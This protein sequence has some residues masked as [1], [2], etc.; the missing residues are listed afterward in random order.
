MPA[1]IMRMISAAILTFGVFL[2]MSYL[3]APGEAPDEPTKN[4][5]RIE[6]LRKNR[7][8]QPTNTDFELPPPPQMAKAPPPIMAR[9][10]SQTLAPSGFQF[11]KSSMPKP[12]VIGDG[13]TANRRAVPVISFPP[14]YPMR[15][16]QNEIEGWVM[17]EFTIAVDG[18][19]TDIVV[20]DA[21]PKNA[22]GFEREAIRVMAR[23]SYQPKMVDGR[24]VPQHHMREIFRY[25]IK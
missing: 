23:W 20:V 7:P 4:E 18:S 11:I 2:G 14:E 3:I 24:A 15:E 13:G 17:L 6:I 16:L 8:E 10:T 22:K 1:Q 12:T 21:E 5:S 19:V 25:E 9:A